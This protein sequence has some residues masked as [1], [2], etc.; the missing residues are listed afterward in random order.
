MILN[1]GSQPGLTWIEVLIV[2]AIIGLL[3]VLFLNFFNPLEKRDQ[4]TNSR[5]KSDLDRLAIALED[6][7]NDKGCYPA[8][9]SCETGEAD[10]LRPYLGTI[11]CDPATGGSYY[12]YPEDGAS[13]PKHYR[14]YTTLKW[15]KDPAIAAVGCAWG[16]GPIKAGQ[17]NFPYNFPFN[18]GVSSPNVNLESGE[19]FCAENNLWHA[20]QKGSGC[21][22]M[23]SSWRECCPN[24]RKQCP[25]KYT[26][27]KCYC[28]EGFPAC[29]GECN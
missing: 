20:C 17:T 11:P 27:S 4:A 2:V 12:Y 18:Y 28:N 6:Y 13:C 29:G 1:T 8:E 9:V 23:G 14:I 10:K 19:R 16:C 21:N 24:P 22:V 26:G 15:E 3:A 25:T 7:Y 5:Q